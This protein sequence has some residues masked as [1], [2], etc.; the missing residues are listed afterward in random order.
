[1]ASPPEFERLPEAAEAGGWLVQD[2]EAIAA[3]RSVVWELIKQI[4]QNLTSGT[5]LTSITLPIN[6]SE[7]RSYLEMVADGWCYAPLFL[8]QASVEPDPVE[9]MKMVITFAVAG[10]SNTCVVKK[11]FNPIVGETME[12]M[13]EDGTE[14]YCEQVSH[15]PPVTNW[16]MVGPGN[17]FH[18]YGSGELSASFRA[19][20]VRGH[21]EGVHCVDFSLDNG[22]ITYNL[23]EVWVRGVAW[24][25]RII[26]YDGIMTFHDV[27]NK[28]IAEVKINRPESG[29]GWFSW[30]KKDPTDYLTGHIYKY[31][32]EPEG[33]DR[34]AVSQVSGSWMGCVLFD[35]KRYWSHKDQLPKFGLTQTENPLPSDSRYRE[36]VL[37]LR[38]DNL[39]LA[40]EWKAKL[41]DKQRAEAKTRKQYC[42]KNGIDY[43]PV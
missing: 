29:G 13:F 18:F 26:E 8:K 30:K 25:E 39:E 9:R 36:D 37:Y 24:G 6:I 3:Q 21:Q 4:G 43:V 1:M 7:P 19:N 10:L 42:Q 23:P 2:E 40:A 33:N 14:I 12:G 34:Q 38:S 28:I 20:S 27:A 31:K 5:S 35:G 16:E 17:M 11:P 32:N 41:E 22:R 15:H